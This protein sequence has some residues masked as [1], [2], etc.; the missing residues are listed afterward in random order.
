M[1]PDITTAC[2]LF[3]ISLADPDFLEGGSWPK[4]R[5]LAQRC[6]SLPEFAAT[7]PDAYTLPSP[8]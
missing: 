5:A 7:R 3:Y 1:Q 8:G 6:E 2:A 4:L